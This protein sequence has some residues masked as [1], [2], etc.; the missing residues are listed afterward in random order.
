[1][2]GGTHLTGLRSAITRVINDY[3]RRNNLLKEADQ[4]FSGDDTRE[5]L[6]AIVSIKHPDP[7]SLKARPRS[8]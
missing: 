6:T 4:N 2:D 5:G 1:M 7:R 3:A 8:N